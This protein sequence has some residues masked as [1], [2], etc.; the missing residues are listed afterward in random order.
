DFEPADSRGKVFG[1]DIKEGSY[2]IEIP[3]EKAVGK[4]V[5]RIESPQPTGR[6]VPAGPPAARGAM[7]DEIAEAVPAQYN[8]K[9]TLQ[10]D[11]SIASPHNFELFSHP[12]SDNS[13]RPA[14]N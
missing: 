6:K 7:I 8:T 10:V 14:T 11:L 13:A 2:R 12:K 9:S 1:A 4:S 5:V 3:Q